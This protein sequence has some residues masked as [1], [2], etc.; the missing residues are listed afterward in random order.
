MVNPNNKRHFIAGAKCPRCHMS[1]TIVVFKIAH[2]D[3]VECV[4]CDFTETRASS[5]KEPGKK[6]IWLNSDNENGL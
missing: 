3:I 2:N 4:E 6:V 5:L 1:D